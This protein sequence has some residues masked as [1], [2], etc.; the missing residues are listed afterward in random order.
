MSSGWPV[1]RSGHLGGKQPPACGAAQAASLT[2]FAVRFSADKHVGSTPKQ[3]SGLAS[4]HECSGFGD[5]GLG[6]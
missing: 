6:F 5:Q 2:P 4:G 1:L 3:A